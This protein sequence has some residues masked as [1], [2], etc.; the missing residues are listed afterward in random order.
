MKVFIKNFIR[1]FFLV[2]TLQISAQN[3]TFIKSYDHDQLDFGFAVQQTSDGGF[4]LFGESGHSGGG[5][6]EQYLE[7]VKTDPSGNVVWNNSFG[8]PGLINFGISAKQTFDNGYILCGSYG[9]LS[10]DTLVLVKTDP[11]GNE[12]WHY[13]Y[14][15]HNIK[16]VGQS[17]LQTSDSGYIALGFEGDGFNPGVYIVKTDK[18]GSLQ[19]SKT[20][21]QTGYEI[22]QSIKQVG[23]N[24]YIICG[25]TDS[26]GHG[27]FDIYIMRLNLNGDSLWTKTFGTA[28]S[29]W[30]TAVDVTNDGGFIITG[31]DYFSGGDIWLIKTDSSGNEQWVKKFGGPGW[32]MGNDVKQCT[33]GGYVIAGRKEIDDNRNHF[34]CIRTNSLGN[35]IWEHVFPKDTM[36]EAYSVFQNDDKGFIFLG[37]NFNLDSNN[38]DFYYI[39]LDS[40]GAISVPEFNSSIIN[41][42]VYPN[43]T[44][45]KIKV[46]LQ[47]QSTGKISFQINDLLGRCILRKEENDL[48]SIVNEQID[49]S[50]FTNGVYF[51]LVEFNEEIIVRKII[52]N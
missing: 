4:M 27:D 25:R 36:S 17:V 42:M 20:F 21:P 3:I 52:K 45:E 26:K 40:T 8:L 33:D 50:N 34:Y 31:Y 10:N 49:L 30:G 29:E 28:L 41:F 35:I 11:L 38:T 7:L 19:W 22:C 46:H 23:N 1:I 44:S 32:D 12:E 37:N 9:D 48:I 39:R 24:G 13:T 43:P 14:S 15:A 47:L 51:L 18:N 5:N 6:M 2:I 16:D